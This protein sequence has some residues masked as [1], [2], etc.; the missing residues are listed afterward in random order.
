VFPKRLE[1]HLIVSVQ[2]THGGLLFPQDVQPYPDRLPEFHRLLRDDYAQAGGGVSYGWRDWD[3]SFSILKTVSG[4]NTHD[5]H[6]Y[7][8][9]AGRSFRIRR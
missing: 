4:M 5:V 6:I 9:T 1:G 3:L 7:T 8:A 2:R